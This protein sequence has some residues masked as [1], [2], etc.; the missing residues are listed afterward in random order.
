MAL[1]AVSGMLFLVPLAAPTIASGTASPTISLAPNVFF[2]TAT[3]GLTVSIA[4]PSSNSYAIT[5]FTIFPTSS[6]WVMSGSS[7]SASTFTCSVLTGGSLQCVNGDLAPGGSVA[8]TGVSLQAPAV[9]SYPAKAALGSTVQF[10]SS[11]AFSTG[12]STAVYEIETGTTVSFTPSSVTNFV[13][14]SAP[15]SLS[16]ALSNADDAGIPVSLASTSGTFSASSG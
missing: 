12:P 11:S 4:N 16:V 3:T 2:G 10:A 9:S 7:P 14:G 5:G 6:S 13:A 1:L 8:V 15:L